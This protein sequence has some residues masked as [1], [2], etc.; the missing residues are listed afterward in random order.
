MQGW[1]VALHEVPDEVFA[2]GLLG[3]GLAIDPTGSTIHAPCDGEVVSLARTGH[4]IT[5]R[6]ENGAEILIHIGLD[7][8]GLEGEGFQAHVAEG[9]RV[10]SGAPL[11]SFDIDL[12]AQRAASLL[13]PIVVS[14]PGFDVVDARSD[15]RTSP[16]DRLFS[17]RART[18]PSAAAPTPG[19]ER[20]ASRK[21]VLPLR[22]GLHARP[23]ALL[24]KA[25]AATRSEIEVLCNGREADARSPVALMTLGAAFGADLLITARG[26]DAEAAIDALVQVLVEHPEAVRPPASGRHP[27]APHASAGGAGELSQPAA[28][29]RGV[30]AAPGLAIGPAVRFARTE[31]RVDATAHGVTYEHEAL[32]RALGQVR[33]QISTQALAGGEAQ[34]ILTAHLAFL[35]DPGLAST[36]GRLIDQGRSAGVAWREA[37]ERATGALRGVA[38]P[39]LAARV[40]DLVDVELRVLQA[41]AGGADAGPDLPDSGILLAHE[42]LPSDLTRLDA[43]RLGGLVTAVGGPTSHVAILAAGMGLPMLVGA[44]PD[45]LSTPQGAEIILDADAGLLDSR[46]SPSAL[47]A[48]RR[49]LETRRTG[50]GQARAAASQ[51][52]RTADGVVIEILANLASQSEAHAAAAQG[53]DGCGLLRTEFLFLERSAAP[54]EA[55][56]LGV[57]QAIADAL[58]GRPITLRTLDIG[59]DKPAA[60]LRMPA[61]ENPALGLRGVR[62]SLAYPELLETQL[63]AALRVR[64]AGQCRIMLPMVSSV[65]E[66]R[67]VRALVERLA[68][69]ADAGE[70]QLG[71]MVETPAAALIAARLAEDADFFSIGSNDLAQYAL[72]MDRGDPRLAAQADAL[73]PAVLRLIAL[74]AEGAAGRE[75][76]VGVCGGLAADP[77]AAPLL[78]GLGVRALSVPPARIPVLKANVR[79]LTL[80]VCRDLAQAALTRATAAEVRRLVREALPESA[81]A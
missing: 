16:G 24:A 15:C 17:L 29:I 33:Q 8:V 44:G 23:A 73:H 28:V 21:L 77:V 9:Q 52:C 26:P 56:Q 32:A 49:R 31:V 34:S 76:P 12:V 36:A 5:L 13:T 71:I 46:P 47:E 54:D 2:Q 14:S 74:T 66:L 11:L 22:S 30:T 18:A 59:A 20:Q 38:D 51:P 35:E 58:P 53:A 43:A 42:L 45:I 41:L 57:Y 50:V 7:T 61:E 69:G 75:R 70:V 55:E 62:V 64:P 80:A 81:L 19:S 67:T 48:A 25:A 79:T 60:Y 68:P 72:A 27:Q 6:A 78:I 40:D 63:R 39:L 37:V 65:D 1:L 3:D 4:A 10:L